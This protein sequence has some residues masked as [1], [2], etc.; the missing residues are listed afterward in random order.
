MTN[1][2]VSIIIPFYNTP[3]DYWFQ[4]L[5]SLCQQTYNNIEIIVVDD[6]SKAEFAK[7]LD[8]TSI[9]D[10][11]L[12]IYHK[13]N[14]GVSEARNYALERCTGNFLCFV[15]SDDWVEP[16]FVETLVNTLQQSGK[17]LAACNW[18]AE[19]GNPT[20]PDKACSNLATLSQVEAYKALICSTEI[21]GFLWN[22]IFEKN[23][24]TQGLD[25]S[26]C[27]CEDFVFNAHYLS[28]IDG[29]AFVDRQLYHYR[30]TGGNATGDFSF[31]NRIFTL[32]SAYQKAEAIYNKYASEYQYL[33][34]RNVLKTALNL[35]ARMK[36]NNVTDKEKKIVINQ[37]IREYKNVFLSNISIAD[38]INILLTWLFP[39]IMFRLKNKILKRKI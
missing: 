18:I 19:T 29:M 20:H 2:L 26:L 24:V 23:L 34:R 1:S 31:N 14:G 38:K 21:L 39:V 25:E 3:L 22:K 36:Y 28:A 7:K 15:D 17:H 5:D 8:A 13:P 37:T 32:I 35:R 12:K 4:C 16:D 9:R 11:R 10:S 6:G 30:Q 33:V 27:Y